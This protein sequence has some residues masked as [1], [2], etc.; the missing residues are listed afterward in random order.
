M[1]ADLASS[2]LLA[3][4]EQLK[5]EQQGRLAIRDGSAYAGLGAQAAVVAAVVSGQSPGLLLL[6][7]PVVFLLGWTRLTNDRKVSSIR[8]YV[9]EELAPGLAALVGEGSPVLFGWEA[10]DEPR[11]TVHKG[12]QLLA[13]LLAFVVLPLAALVAYLVAARGPVPLGMVAGVE[14]VLL[15]G[16]A[17]EVVRYSEVFT[18]GA[19]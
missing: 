10:A 15:A 19:L 5:K 11:R 7:P 13:D 1:N 9:R 2:V 16:L 6:L 18:R 3:E 17:A 12:G 14:A 4:Y 8:R